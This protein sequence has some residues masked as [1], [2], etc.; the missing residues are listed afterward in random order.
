MVKFDTYINFKKFPIW[1][2]WNQMKMLNNLGDVKN[3][4]MELFYF[5]NRNKN[6]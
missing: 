6:N 1:S 3:L 5:K 2:K 4:R